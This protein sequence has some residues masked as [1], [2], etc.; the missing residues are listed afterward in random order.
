MIV[1]TIQLLSLG[2]LKWKICSV[3]NSRLRIS[4]LAT[5]VP[6][7]QY[8]VARRASSQALF[9]GFD[10]LELPLHK[11]CCY[12]GTIESVAASKVR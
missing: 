8:V 3:H 2:N 9:T 5:E 4:S 7:Y 12:L 11:L 1:A 10:F 6:P